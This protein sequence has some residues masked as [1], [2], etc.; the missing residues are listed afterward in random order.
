MEWLGLDAPAYLPGRPLLGHLG[1]ESVAARDAV[2]TE[3]RPGGKNMKV[4]HT[5][6]WKY[7]YYHGETY[8]ELFNLANDPDEHHN[9]FADPGYAGQRRALH[10]RLLHEL[11]ET[12]STWP[13]KGG[14]A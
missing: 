5:P 12:E 6:D 13:A 10:D 3:Y 14:W 7:V 8:G 9:L 2:L 4:L 1:G 11:V